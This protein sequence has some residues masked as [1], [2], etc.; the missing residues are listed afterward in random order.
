MY[1]YVRV[2]FGFKTAGSGFIRE[3]TLALLSEVII[4]DI[5]QIHR[6][7]D[8]IA[9]DCESEITFIAEINI[10]KQT[11]T[12]VDDCAIGTPTFEQHILVLQIVFSK[13]MANG[14]TINLKNLISIN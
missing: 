10:Q 8:E 1:Q 3:F 5:F 9:S 14:F 4:I 6:K 2:P 7:F 12:Y 13:L 11:A